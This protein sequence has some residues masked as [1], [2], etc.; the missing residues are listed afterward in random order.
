MGLFSKKPKKPEIDLAISEEHKKK[1]REI[2]NDTV[3]NGDDFQIIY[4]YSTTSKYEQGFVFNTQTTTFYEYVI[5]YRKSDYQVVMVQIS[6]DMKEHSD[7]FYLE[8]D[9]IVNISYDPKLCQACLQY[10]K[11]YSSY[12]EILNI[13]DCSG[14]AVL[15]AANL[16]Q[17]AEREAFLDFLETLRAELQKKGYKLDKWKR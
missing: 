5:G 14:K 6:G 1:L 4:G 10:E 8:M 13:K 11:G 16:E 15:G 3:D 7:A 2:F 12:G 17:G 9:K